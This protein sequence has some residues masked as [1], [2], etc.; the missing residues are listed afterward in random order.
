M[1][2]TRKTIKCDGLLQRKATIERTSINTESRTVEL[3]V[4]SETPVGRWFGQEILDHSANSIR[5]ERIRT[6]GP[7][8]VD[9]Y[10]DQVGV[11]DDIR[12]D[13]STRR[14]VARLR[15]S[16]SQRAQEVFQD[17]ADGIRQNVSIGYQVHAMRLESESDNEET[18]RA[19]DWELYEI[20]IVSIPADINVG[21]GRSQTFANEIQIDNRGLNM[22]DPV[23]AP[24]AQAQTKENIDVQAIRAQ[25]QTDELNRIRSLTTAGEKF[26]QYGGVELARQMIEGGKSVQEFREAILEKIPT[27]DKVGSGGTPATALDL[28]QKELRGYSLFRAINAAA[29]KDWSKAGFERECSVEISDKL[30]REARGFFVPY[31]V[32]AKRVMSTGA[33]SGGKLVAV[34]QMPDQ[35]ID[36][37]R[38]QTLVARLGARYLTGLVGNPDIPA[39]TSGATFYWLNED[40]NVT[41]SDL[42]LKSVGLSPKTV[43]GSVA[44]TR[45]L[46]MQSTPDIEGLVQDDLLQG[47][48]IAIDNAVINGLGTAASKQPTG[49]LAQAGVKTVAIATAGAPTRQEMRKFKTQLKKDNAFLGSPVFLMNPDI[50]GTLEDTPID[51]GSGRFVLENGKVVGLPVESTNLMPANKIL[52]GNFADVIIGMWGVLDLMPDTAAKAASGGLVLRVFQDVDVAIRHAESF[53]KSA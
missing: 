4:S 15:F 53:V 38:M 20:S 29:S 16:N 3:P 10:S 1:P 12:L 31:D 49:I 48:A 9:H 11:V 23:K 5:L 50:E 51:T 45:R 35:F 21:V 39:A 18:Y 27:I 44:M 19:T 14:L 13:P 34:E 30:G 17:I 47:M 40:E 33:A 32:L 6:G 7:V 36:R 24:E 41:D 43:A 46:L 52:L 26:A 2:Q 22:P 37:L 25:A 28:T 8:L 42:G